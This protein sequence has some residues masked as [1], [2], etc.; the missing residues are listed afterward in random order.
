MLDF[1][2]DTFLAVCKHM[3]YTRAADELGLTQPAV[4]QHI[5]YLENVYGTKLFEYQAKQLRLTPQG[6]LLKES[7]ESMNHDLG[8][9][10]SE[11][12]SLRTAHNLRIGATM[13]VGNYYISSKL[14]GFIADNPELNVSITVADTKELLA[15]LGNGE[16][17][18][19]LCEG[20]FDKT[21]YN[22]L[23]IRNEK[24][25]PFCS[26]SYDTSG[27][28]DLESIF[29][30]R[31]FLREDG[32]GTR[33]VFESYLKERGFSLDCFQQQCDCNSP[34]VITNLLKAGLGISFMYYT[35]GAKDVEEGLL[36]VV[37]LTD[38]SLKHEFN[39]VWQKNSIYEDY[40]RGCIKALL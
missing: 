19:I 35:V 13:S 27:I 18:F 2:V 38:F 10:K 17:D 26:V 12:G 3:N 33:E 25:V 8:R 1:R 9:L 36:K 39:A 40:Y 37:E 6:E 14:A 15:R 11:M 31:I 34:Q 28:T 21:K 16:I 30:H 4:S 24:I 7:L 32:S 23:L 29:S 20:N 5:R 22:H